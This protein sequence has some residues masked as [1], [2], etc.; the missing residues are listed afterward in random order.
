M[1]LLLNEKH[2]TFMCIRYCLTCWNKIRSSS[3]NKIANFTRKLPHWRFPQVVQI[4]LLQIKC[5]DFAAATY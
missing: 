4:L 1:I 2:K 5:A 3:Q